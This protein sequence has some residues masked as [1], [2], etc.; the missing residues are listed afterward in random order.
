[1]TMSFPPPSQFRPSVRT[2]RENLPRPMTSFIGRH[3]EL[4]A[5][6]ALLTSQGVRLVTL[7]GPGG[8][9]KTRLA[10]EGAKRTSDAVDDIWFVPLATV[11]DTAQLS[12]AIVRAMGMVRIAGRSIE[13]ELVNQ[14][15]GANTL[16]ILDNLEQLPGAGEPISNLLRRCPE[17]RILATSRTSMRISGEQVLT[18]PA[19][20]VPAHGPLP[21]LDELERVE[22]VRLFVERARASDATFVLT[23]RNSAAVAHICRH[24]DGLPL[25]IELAAAR[26]GALSPSTLRTLVGERLTLLSDGPCDES[27]RLRSMRDSIA[28]SYE[29]L[30]ADERAVFAQLA[31][32]AGPWTLESAE[33]VVQTE[34]A[35]GDRSVLECVIALI[36]HNLIQRETDSDG[37]SYYL[38]LETI[39]QFAREQLTSG[40]NPDAVHFRHSALI[41]GLAQQAEVALY[42]NT[43]AQLFTQ[44]RVQHADI[45]QALTW[46]EQRGDIDTLIE[47]CSGLRT[48]WGMQG[49]TI[50]GRPWLERAVNLGRKSASPLL[51]TALI[52]LATCLH[53]QGN[54]ASARSLA[55]EGLHLLR[56]QDHAI[57]RFTAFTLGGL[58]SLRLGAFEE[59]ASRQKDALNLIRMMPSAQWV[60]CAESSVLGHLGNIAVSQG[61]IE[62]A[63][64]FFRQALER[65]TALGF[66]RGTS[67]LMASH[68]I[69]G[70]GDIARAE[71]D[72]ATALSL[73]QEALGIAD[74]FQDFRATVYALGGV[75]GSL[76]AAGDWAAA[77][78]LFGAC[79]HQHQRVGFPFDLETMDRQRALGLPEPWQ[80]ASHSFG[81]NQV[82]RDAVL[83]R[84]PQP[85]PPLPDPDSAADT[86]KLGRNLSLADAVSLA[87]A[88]RIE[89][90]PGLATEA[91]SPREV[92]VLRL[93][94]QGKTDQEIGNLLFISRRTASTHVRHIYDKL[95]VS[96][97]AAATAYALRH[98]LA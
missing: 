10:I 67:H 11:R 21:A 51:G 32:F 3:R 77:A 42:T 7:T 55:D 74:G 41:R 26:S 66:T 54:E 39:R 83:R 37:S 97:R 40:N 18:V 5:I 79:E 47:T 4:D 46:L 45:L 85:L 17:L 36:H 58:I 75:A 43:G 76:A 93:V 82:L 65:Q 86:W 95:D 70:L 2:V 59:S 84:N 34:A 78:T 31:V 68:P 61:K 24:L 35:R 28:W 71:S 13:E 57:T 98:G 44:L 15:T 96:S 20:T 33:A 50:E 29:L 48:F 80:R 52:A 60:T 62:D 9:G 73:Y 25:A 6:H 88:V 14:F 49:F 64:C 16:L 63:R 89:P 53:M 92:E 30:Q 1:M 23:E 12:S 72:L 90:G 19:M 94:V 87:L 38:L 8:V 56:A 81:A 22:A 91:L 27:P 69:A